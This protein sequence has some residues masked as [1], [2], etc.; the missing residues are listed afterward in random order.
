[1]R[2]GWVAGVVVALAACRDGREGDAAAADGDADGSADDGSDDGADPQARCEAS[3]IGPRMLRRLTREELDQ[4]LR[5]VF[6]ELGDAWSGVRL[7]P[8]PLSALGF[9]NDAQMLQVGDQTAADLLDTAIDVATLV[10]APERLPTLLPCAAAAAD[11]ACA[12][13]F[14]TRYGRRL[15]R[16]PLTA[17]ELASYRDLFASNAAE[18]DFATSLRWVVVALIQSPHAIYRSELGQPSDDGFALDDHEL[19]TA[20]AYDFSGTTPTEALLDA[21]ESGELRDPLRRVQWARMLLDSAGGRAT[22]QRFGEQWA[23][24]TRVATAT[25]ND[26]PEFDG[27]RAAMI[28]ET[29][30]LFAATWYDDD[31][32]VRD[33]LSTPDTTVEPALAAFYGWSAL[34]TTARVERPP[35]WGVGLLAQ[36]SVLAANAHADASSPTKRG[37]LVYRR[38][39]CQQVPP[40]PPGVPPLDATG[41]EAS[42]TRERYETLHASSGACAACHAQFD[43]IG[44]A[45]EHFDAT[46][47]WR[48]LDNGHAIDATGTLSLPDVDAL[49]FDGL[50]ALAQTL[51]ERDEV[52]DCASGLAAAWLFG[53]AG[54]QGCLAED[55]RSELVAGDIGMI[56]YL[57]ELAAAPHFASRRAP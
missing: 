41:D 15:F 29:R 6:V 14:V 55:A 54:G 20:L 43:P 42:T 53:G 28:A 49:G 32:D 38:L 31:G 18:A 22:V 12:E 40:P 8:D 17:D 25:K 24:Y 10:T 51:A 52:T 13:T 45:F 2:C 26:V 44:F 19:A 3:E 36:G 9:S 11:A 34:E 50:D 16:R 47:R 1:M 33:L 35:H 56:D 48:E 39:L 46:G 7:G 37:L 27:L 23:G 21:A 30:A 5:D 4:S 57:A